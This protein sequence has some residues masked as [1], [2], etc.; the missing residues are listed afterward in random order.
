MD[1]HPIPARGKD[2]AHFHFDVR[3]LL[4]TRPRAHDR[5]AAEDPSRP[6]RWTSFEDA[7]A[8]GADDSLLRA[9][10]KAHAILGVRSVKV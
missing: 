5:S 2:P 3:Y 9:L 4:V 7:L 8:A 10:D 1:V 6:M